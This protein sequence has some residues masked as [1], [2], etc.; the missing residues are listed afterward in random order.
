MPESGRRTGF[1]QALRDKPP[2]DGTGSF[3]RSA[4]S[5]RFTG[6]LNTKVSERPMVTGDAGTAPP[7]HD[8]LF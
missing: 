5:A 1:A 6:K 4:I 2:R 7:R 8:V 3:T